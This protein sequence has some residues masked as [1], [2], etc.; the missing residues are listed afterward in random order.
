MNLLAAT[1]VGITIA[2]L[3]IAVLPTP[4]RVDRRIAPYVQTHRRRS[5]LS[6]DVAVAV[7]PGYATNGGPVAAVRRTI[8]NGAGHILGDV[9]DSGDN[10]ELRLRLRRAGVEPPTAATYRSHQMRSATIGA[11]IA[12][13]LCLLG[14]LFNVSLILMITGLG[15]LLGAVVYKVRLERRAA[16]RTVEMQLALYTVTQVL[17]VLTRANRGPVGAVRHLATLGSGP[18]IEELRLA[19]GWIERGT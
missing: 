9:V 19:I 13:T 3:V 5:G 17:A 16:E 14:Q 12:V 7:D 10:D 15:F 4:V 1:L 6:S 18:L 8:S 2:L 11:G